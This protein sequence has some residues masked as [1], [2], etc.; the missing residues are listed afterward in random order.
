MKLRDAFAKN[1]RRFRAQRGLSQEELA[2]LA[3][4][5]RGYMSDLERS[6][7]SASLDI[8]ERLAK[9]LKVDPHE[10]LYKK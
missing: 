10:L 8:V 2:H 4:V 1:L 3:G 6:A 7:Y 9:V 5:S